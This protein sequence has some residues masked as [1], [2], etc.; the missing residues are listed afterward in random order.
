MISQIEEIKGRIDIA[1]LVGSYVRLQKAGANFKALCPF[2]NEKTP[3]FN[4]SP[5]RQIW[6]CFG[7]GMGGDIFEFIQKIDGVAFVDALKTLA[8]RAGVELKREDPQFRT[9]RN[10]QLALLE[11]AAKFF[12]GNLAVAP[13][14]GG[15]AAEEYLKNRGLTDDTIRE[16]RLG[17]APEEW[18]ALSD[19]LKAKGFSAS[20]LL[21]SGLVVQSGREATSYYDR[22]RGRIMFPIFDYNGRVVAF[23]GRIYPEKNNEPKYV[24]SPETPLYNKSKILY[25]LNKSKQEILRTGECVLVEGYMDMIMSYQ[26]GVRNVAAVS[27]TALT[28]EQLKPIKRLAEKLIVAFDVDSAGEGAAKRGIALALEQE[29]DVRVA[30]VLE[31]GLKD[32]ADAAAKSPEIWLRAITASRHI[33][34]FYMDSVLQKYKA[35]SPEAKRAFQK[36]VLPVIASL[37]ELERAHWVREAGNILNIKEEAI[38][39]ALQRVST[40]INKYQQISDT[41]IL[42]TRDTGILVDTKK[43]KTLLREKILSITA[44]YPALSEKIEPEIGKLLPMESRT[45]VFAEL[46]LNNLSEAEAELVKCQR[47]F[48]KEYLKEQ[49]EELSREI[50]AKERSGGADLKMLLEDFY[51]ISKEL[52]NI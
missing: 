24:N 28:A 23:G 36:T 12:E 30:G 5:T 9:E 46:L 4:V 45:A 27:G 16:F 10:R 6:H 51:K 3:S 22:F 52:T 44:K 41:K 39:N 33:A 34:G 13:P 49:L 35:V 20:E 32:P 38:W 43:R 50:S 47:E 48:K 31:A 17:Y 14:S 15:T 8:D 18:R 11:E 7:C 37:P 42:D 21:K 40:N 2:H 1:D 25:G 19:Y 26:A 29:F